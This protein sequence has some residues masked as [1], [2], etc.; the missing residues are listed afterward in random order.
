MVLKIFNIKRH[1]NPL[2]L[3]VGCVIHTIKHLCSS[4][5]IVQ[6][7]VLECFLCFM[8]NGLPHANLDSIPTSRKWLIDTWWSGPLL[9]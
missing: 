2:L 5:C 9:D 8:L 7:V 4:I 3:Q 1:D 6:M